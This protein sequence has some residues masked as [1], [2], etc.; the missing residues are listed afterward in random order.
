MNPEDIF[1]IFEGVC[2]KC[3]KKVKIDRAG[4]SEDFRKQY[5]PMDFSISKFTY[6]QATPYYSHAIGDITYVCPEGHQ[7]YVECS[8]YGEWS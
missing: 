2:P 3:G 1:K 4:G 8:D 7:S 6:W 5:L